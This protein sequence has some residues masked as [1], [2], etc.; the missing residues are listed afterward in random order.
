MEHDAVA[1]LRESGDHPLMYAFPH[2]AVFAFDT[3][4]RYL[5]AGGLGLAD[6]GLSR[7]A[8]EG[9]TIFEVFPAETAAAIEPYYRAALEGRSTVLDVP[10]QGHVYTQRLAPVREAD[11]TIVA[12]IGFTQDVTEA[13][14]VEHALRE[15]EQRN[16]LSFSHAPVGKAIVELDGRWRQVNA[17]VVEVTGYSE[18]QLV[19]MTFQ[20]IT[21][22]DDL[23][24]DLSHLARLVAGEITSYQIEKRYITASGRIV[25]VLLSVSLVRD[26]DGAPQY[27]IA[28]IQDITELTRQR[29]ALKD[30]TAML[31]HDLRTATAVVSGFAEMLSSSWRDLSDAE[32]DQLLGRIHAASR[33]MLALLDNSLTASTLDSG[34][35]ETNPTD[36]EIGAAITDVAAALGLDASALDLHGVSPAVA[37]IDPTHLHQV[38]VNLLSN[39][40]KYGGGRISVRTWKDGTS[41]AV[42]IADDGAG[43]EAEFV[44]HL[45]DR[46][47]RSGL[48]RSGPERGTGLG[49]S[50]VHDLLGLNHGTIAY[51]TSEWGGAQFTFRVPLA[52]FAEPG[53]NDQRTEALR[54]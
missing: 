12:G 54:P 28:Q 41:V 45:F 38:L 9:R 37:R 40:R 39:A 7:E 48:A 31:A 51:S 16:R 19:G 18:E 13:R 6:V 27:F 23:E 3:E 11:G 20:D 47:T 42:A 21:H 32:R 49:L 15:S 52:E 25:Q 35:L 46:F 10:Y 43:V 29:Q 1:A 5:A 34:R 17:A 4:L 33:G 26:D 53:P 2:G 24:L 14:N 30:L 50:I 36:V 44:P 8:M 22:P